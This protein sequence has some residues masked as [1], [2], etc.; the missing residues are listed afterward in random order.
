MVGFCVSSVACGVSL[1]AD[2]KSLPP[3]CSSPKMTD[4]EALLVQLKVLF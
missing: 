2:F 3:K 4:L 1:G